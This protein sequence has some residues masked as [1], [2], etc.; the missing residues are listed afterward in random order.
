MSFEDFVQSFIDSARY[1]DNANDAM[2]AIEIIRRR[3]LKH[4][5]FTMDEYKKNEKTRLLWG[6]EE[7]AGGYSRKSSKKKQ[8][9]DMKEFREHLVDD[10]KK[11]TSLIAFE[12]KKKADGGIENE[13]V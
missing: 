12:A 9:A 7:D 3:V 13:E 4:L 5:N 8:N 1:I 11:L 10:L 6:D 2:Q